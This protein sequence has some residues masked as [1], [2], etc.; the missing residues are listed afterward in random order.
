MGRVPLGTNRRPSVS[1][2]EETPGLRA[3]PIRYSA[4][5][6]DRFREGGQRAAFLEHADDRI[7]ARRREMQLADGWLEDGP[8]DVGLQVRAELKLLGKLLLRAA[9][10]LGQTTTCFVVC[11]G[12]CTTCSN[13]SG[14]A[15][16]T[17]RFYVVKGGS[18]HRWR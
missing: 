2:A 18:S 17:R 4:R 14:P 16:M 8:A 6:P 1:A 9:S 3:G 10:P 15:G 7:S 11:T 12:V 5:S 13:V